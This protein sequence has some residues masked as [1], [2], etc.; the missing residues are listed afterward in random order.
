MNCFKVTN[1]TC[2][3]TSWLRYLLLPLPPCTMTAA[4][5]PLPGSE[6]LEMTVNII[7]CG[8]AIASVHHWTWRLWAPPHSDIEIENWRWWLT[9][10]GMH[11]PFVPSQ[12]WL[13]MLH[14]DFLFS[15]LG[16]W[17]KS[18]QHILGSS[19]G[20]GH[21]WLP[22]TPQPLPRSWKTS[23]ISQVNSVPTSTNTTSVTMVWPSAQM[24]IRKAE[25]GLL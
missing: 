23:G 9:S 19:K 22:S 10:I 24:S 7:F 14:Q 25:K 12:K 16:L 4:P 1:Y 5:I 2:P 21:I 17:E 15:V 8:G 13:T 6:G 18:E 20:A 3:Q 11:T